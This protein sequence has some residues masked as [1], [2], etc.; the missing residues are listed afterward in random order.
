M[1]EQWSIQWSLIVATAQ[2]TSHWLT[3]VLFLMV[4][5]HSDRHFQSVCR[6]P[7]TENGDWKVPQVVLILIFV[8]IAFGYKNSLKNRSLHFQGQIFWTWPNA[9]SRWLASFALM[10]LSCKESLQ[11]FEKPKNDRVACVACSLAPSRLWRLDLSSISS[12][13]FQMDVSWGIYVYVLMLS[14]W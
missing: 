3:V 12:G 7:T 10:F 8:G 4:M 5:R 1:D 6:Y 14:V 13:W 11:Q 9:L 2:E